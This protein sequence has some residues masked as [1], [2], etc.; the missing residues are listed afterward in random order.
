MRDTNQARLKADKVTQTLVIDPDRQRKA[1][2]PLRRSGF[3]LAKLFFSHSIKI[4]SL[5][6]N[7][8]MIVPAVADGQAIRELDMDRRT[9]KTN[10]S[11]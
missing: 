9:N 8:P 5:L 11:P 3:F 7:H 2:P 10:P 4:I 6:A 1:H